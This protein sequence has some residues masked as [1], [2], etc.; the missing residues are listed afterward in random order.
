[1]R[2]LSGH[3]YH[4]KVVKCGIRLVTIPRCTVE[5]STRITDLDV[6]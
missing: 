5:P 1:M 3:H 4:E 2:W 6:P